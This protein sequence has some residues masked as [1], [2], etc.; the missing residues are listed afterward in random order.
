MVQNTVKTVHFLYKLYKKCGSA[1]KCWR[2]CHPTFP[3]NTIPSLTCI[4]IAINK[5]WSTGSL[6]DK[7][8]AKRGCLLTE[9]KL[10]EIG[11]RLQHT[12]QKSLRCLT[13]EPSISK[14]VIALSTK[15]LKLH[16]YKATNSCLAT[17]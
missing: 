2:K 8:Y 4:H 3:G 15:L 14:S 12:P 6:L 17:T 1:K 10:N 16:Q 5:V 9:E 11:A 7:I 13:Q